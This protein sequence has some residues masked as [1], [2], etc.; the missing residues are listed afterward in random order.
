MQKHVL[1]LFVMGIAGFATHASQAARIVPPASGAI[2]LVQDE[3]GPECRE[4][5]RVEREREVAEHRRWEAEHHQ[6]WEDA[7]HGS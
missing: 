1:V 7:H 2:V 6:R 3:C 4:H 5:R